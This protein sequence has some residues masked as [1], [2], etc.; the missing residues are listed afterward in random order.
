[1]ASDSI[2]A[3]VLL[4]AGSGSRMQGSVE[5]KVLV[6]LGGRAVVLHSVDAF[7]NSGAVQ[8]AVVVYRDEAQRLR[9]S[10]LLSAA[11]YASLRVLWVLGG[12]E[13]QNSVYNALLALDALPEG[14]RPSHVFIHD[15]ARPM[16]L[17]AQVNELLAAAQQ[18][19]ASVLAARVADTLKR[20]AGSAQQPRRCQLQD[21]DRAELWA[22]Q[23]PQ[24][25]ERSLI[26]AA[27]A[28]V[29][30]S[31]GRVTD[32]TSAAVAAGHGVTLVENRHPNPKLTTAADLPYL[33]F[34]LRERSGLVRK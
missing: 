33:E 4:C 25:F 13:R 5:D 2:N 19:G 29:I 22:M 3:A 21:V 17:P 14:E 6:A 27:Y 24:V 1:M 32:D 10:E 12:A 31:A 23:T 20:A 8:M 15:C 28:A 30:G 26:T 34:L 18:D 16:L 9:L 11:P 7:V